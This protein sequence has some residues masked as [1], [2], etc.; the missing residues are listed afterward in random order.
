MKNVKGRNTWRVR[1]EIAGFS[2]AVIFS[3]HFQKR[4]K[5]FGVEGLSVEQIANL[6]VAEI[7]RNTQYVFHGE[8]LDENSN[9]TYVE[10]VVF[11]TRSF[12]FIAKRNSSK[13]VV[14]KNHFEMV[15]CYLVEQNKEKAIKQRSIYL[16][17][18]L[19]RKSYLQFTK[20]VV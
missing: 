14:N 20:G 7:G 13:G 12:V 19:K 8:R 9:N 16:E 4:F 3:Q 10:E 15:T 18:G 5:R 17:R 2:K 1:R 11:L 6:T